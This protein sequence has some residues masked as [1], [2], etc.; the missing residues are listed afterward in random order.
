MIFNEIY[1]AYYNTVAKIIT[2]VIEGKG[3]E[4]DLDRIVAENAF[5]ESVLTFLPSLKGERWQI[6]HNDM[7][8]PLKHKPTMPLTL[9][10]KRWLKAVSLDPRMKLF[11]V[12]IKE[13]GDIEP[14]F[15]SEDYFIYDKYGDGDP[16]EDEKYIEHF[17]T[18]L[19]AIRE[20]HNVRIEMTSR[21]GN[22]IY[23][24]CQP[25]RL[26][27]SEKDDKFRLVTGEK[28][29]ITTLNLSRITKCS[30][31]NGEAPVAQYSC[32]PALDT[33][34]LRVTDERNTLER[35]LMHF[36]HFEKRVQREGD[37]YI[38]YIKYQK[39]DESELVI[40]VL[41]FGPTLEVLGSENFKKL[42]INKLKSQK[43]CEI[44]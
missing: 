19:Y 32:K 2:A 18:L 34:I 43:S 37:H 33:L 6:F 30:L 24:R 35:S 31:Y 1:S 39:D 28:D 25:E 23:I 10:Q 5:G 42:I 9:M 12:E 40:R 7:T 41:S 13:L 17:K 26:E 16:Y 22:D 29:H 21:R 15:T 38:L 14:L 20:K 8:T 4:R 36:A 44:K 11:G 3:D 27:Y